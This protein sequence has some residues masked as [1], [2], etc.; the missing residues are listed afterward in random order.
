MIELEQGKKKKEKEKEKKLYIYFDLVRQPGR[1]D[2]WKTMC[3]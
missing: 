1:T 2:F 3:P